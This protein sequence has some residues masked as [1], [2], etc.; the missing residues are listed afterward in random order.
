[1]GSGQPGILF[2]REQWPPAALAVLAAFVLPA[3]AR[4]GEENVK[5]DKVPKAILDAVKAKFPGA[6]LL[7]ASTEK[8]GDKI[9][10]EGSLTYKKHHHDVTVEADGKIVSVE[11]EIAFKDLPKGVSDAVQAKYPRANY[12]RTEELIKGDGTLHG[13][14]VLMTADATVEVVPDLKGKIL[15]EEGKKKDEGKK[16]TADK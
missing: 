5:L 12:K 8:E 10:Y 3:G 4:A 2:L 16:R 11:R 13:Y 14:E 15:K 9:V 1:V 7:G 6:K